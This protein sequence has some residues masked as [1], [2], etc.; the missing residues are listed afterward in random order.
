MA[1]CLRLL[2]DIKIVHCDLKPD[3]VLL[4]NLCENSQEA[5]QIKLIDF[6]SAFSIYEPE[7]LG[8]ATP[9][10]MPPEVL[11]F[12]SSDAGSRCSVEELLQRGKCWSIDVWSF[13]AILLEIV[14]G[15]PLWLSLKCRV[16]IQNKKVFQMGLFAV[17]GRDY[18]KIRIKQKAVLE[19]LEKALANYICDWENPHD[20]LNL[21]KRMLSWDPKSRISPEDIL[22]HKFLS[23]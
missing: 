8:M 14:T 4:A 23:V 7:S 20:F 21:L 15:V 11:S 5:L 22:K 3:N 16:E 6:G 17:K 12:L 19:D 1:E 2:S 18:E 10:Y 13:G 9:E